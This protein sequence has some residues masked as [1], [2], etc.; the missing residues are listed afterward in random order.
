LVMI[1]TSSVK[2]AASFD[3]VPV[4]TCFIAILNNFKKFSSALA[5]CKSVD[6]HLVGYRFVQVWEVV[7]WTGHMQRFPVKIVKHDQRDMSS[8]I[9][10]S[11]STFNRQSKRNKAWTGLIF[12]TATWTGG[13]IDGH[14]RAILGYF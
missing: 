12:P 11:V 14:F 4:Y 7:Y 6:R 1:L 5:C 9:T 3:V 13:Q 8:P 2:T 10:I